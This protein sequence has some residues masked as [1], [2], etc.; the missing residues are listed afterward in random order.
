M[1][2]KKSQITAFILIGII[3]IIAFGMV[4]YLSNAAKTGRLETKKEDVLQK[5]EQSRKVK[6][7]ITSCMK[8]SVEA[9]V[10][11]IAYNGGKYDLADKTTPVTINNNPVMPVEVEKDGKKELVIPA[12]DSEKLAGKLDNLNPP[13]HISKIY[14]PQALKKSL[15]PMRK[16]SASVTSIKQLVPL[17][18]TKGPNDVSMFVYANP[19]PLGSYGSDSIQKEIKDMMINDV[20]ACITDNMNALKEITGSEIKIDGPYGDIIIGKEDVTANLNMNVMLESQQGGSKSLKFSVV[21]PLRLKRL[22]GVVA[23]MI[24]ND[25]KYLHYNISRDVNTPEFKTYYWDGK[26]KIEREPIEKLNPENGDLITVTDDFSKISGNPLKFRFVRKGDRPPALDFID[27]KEMCKNK[28]CIRSDFADITMTA[29]SAPLRITAMA[30]DPD[31]DVVEYEIEGWEVSYKDKF[32][33]SGSAGGSKKIEKSEFMKGNPDFFHAVGG[34]ACRFNENRLSTYIFRFL[35]PNERVVCEEKCISLVTGQLNSILG[36]EYHYT[37]QCLNNP[38]YMCDERNCKFEDELERVEI[39]YYK[40]A[41]DKK[42]IKTSEEHKLKDECM[43]NDGSI[44][45]PSWQPSNKISNLPPGAEPLLINTYYGTGATF[46]LDIG[47]SDDRHLGIHD[48]TITAREKGN[49]D[50]D[51]AQS[52]HLK[53]R[54]APLDSFFPI[55]AE[56]NPSPNPYAQ[57]PFGF[58]CSRGICTQLTKPYS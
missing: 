20:S 57:C 4:F 37:A 3:M 9:S 24:D 38:G 11:K 44:F 1:P 46:S 48:V 53:I 32:E 43:K 10:Q 30:V 14:Y 35:P 6:D 22:Y 41:C 33:G 28:G 27:K 54:I 5:L 34:W 2:N 18:E 31:E 51:M 39:N 12:M 58:S 17:C 49:P 7:F 13:T 47:G 25:I 16:T 21:L 56:C 40:K 50:P 55:T 29:T 26:M 36:K 45:F 52:Q 8:N 15:H 42:E 23:Y 19:C